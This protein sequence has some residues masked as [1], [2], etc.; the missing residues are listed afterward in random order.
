MK[1]ILPDF[2]LIF[3][4]FQNFDRFD[5]IEYGTYRYVRHIYSMLRFMLHTIDMTDVSIGA[6]FDKIE[7]IEYTRFRPFW[8]KSGVF[9]RRFEYEDDTAGPF[10][11][12]FR[13]GRK[14]CDTKHMEFVSIGAADD[15]IFK[16]TVWHFASNHH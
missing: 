16:K 15:A 12:R 2:F 8:Q 3:S 11:A 13:I 10:R 4:I 6:V 14:I 9:N 7:T 5:L 1:L